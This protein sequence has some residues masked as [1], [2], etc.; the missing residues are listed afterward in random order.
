MSIK[1][2]G[3]KLK[4]RILSVGRKQEPGYYSQNGQDKYLVEKVFLNSRKGIFVDIGAN[5]GI[6]GSNTYYMEN[7]LGWNGICVEPNPAIFQKLK[8]ARKSLL[9]NCAISQEETESTFLKISG[10][11]EMLSGLIEFY[12]EGHLQRIDR[13]LKEH[14]GSKEKIKIRCR[15]INNLLKEN[16]LNT[17]DYLSID[18]EGAELQILRT[19]NFDEI[20]IKVISV[21]NNYNMELIETLM[22]ERGYKLVEILGADDI[23]IRK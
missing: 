10:Y 15:N 9:I 11:A 7:K 22:K 18:T 21:E 8:A 4:N 3:I 2:L 5:D 20:N 12:D 14:G 6:T 23:Y 19:I 16:S 13:E 17:I 1:R